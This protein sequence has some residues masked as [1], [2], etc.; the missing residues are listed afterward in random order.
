MFDSICVRETGFGNDL[1]LAL[2]LL[3]EAL[4]FYERVVVIM[5]RAILVQLLDSLGA[6]G[7]LRLAR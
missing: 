3:A 4:V 2:G 5:N 7:L 6:E 1:P